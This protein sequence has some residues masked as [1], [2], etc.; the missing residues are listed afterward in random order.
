M[1]NLTNGEQRILNSLRTALIDKIIVE[2]LGCQAE[3]S[4]TVCP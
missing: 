3:F 4:I 2:V 1:V